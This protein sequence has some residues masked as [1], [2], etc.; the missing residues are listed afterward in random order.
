[1]PLRWVGVAKT[2]IITNDFP[3]RQ[4]GIERYVHELSLRLPADEVVVYTAAM[5]GSQHVDQQVPFPVIRDPRH[6]LLPT[7]RVARRVK[8]VAQSHACDSVLFGAAAPLGLLAHSLGQVEGIR[9]QVAITHGHEVWWA[10]LPGTRQMLR[11]IGQNVDTVTYLGQFTGTAIGAAMTPAVRHRMVQLT[12]GVDTDRF[13][14]DPDRGAALREE[15]GLPSTA[16]VAICVSRLV[17]RKGQDMLI[18]AWPHVLQQV[19]S[20]H[21]VIVGDGPDQQ[22]LRTLIQRQGVQDSVHLPGSASGQ[23]LVDFYNAANVFAMPCRTRKAGLEPEALGICYLEAQA[24]GLPVLVGNSGGAPDTCVPGV[25]GFVV[26]GRD[27][28]DV[29]QRLILLLGD[30][31]LAQRMGQAGREW[32]VQQWQWPAIVSR[33]QRLLYP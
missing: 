25:S 20:A 30:P 27:V 22:R 2:L 19:A 14:A 6:R 29:A 13:A 1:M 26:Q 21:L 15:L 7:A 18:R 23:R 8:E 4:G 31:G 32:V 17:Q 33:L 9:R 11:R 28:H 24:C 12:P 16:P 3:P 10:R 5:P